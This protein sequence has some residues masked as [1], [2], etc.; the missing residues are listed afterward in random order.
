MAKSE[1]NEVMFGARGRV[2][3][4]VVFKN[5]GNN[6]TVISK[7]PK[8]PENPMY[9]A[10]QVAVKQ[11]FREAVLYAKGAIE[12][13]DLA[14]FYQVFAK[15]GISAYNLALADYCKAPEITLIDTV[16]YQGQISDQIKVRAIDNFRVTEVKVSIHDAADA[17]L[18]SGL[19]TLSANNVD[20]IYESSIQQSNLAGTKIT[21]EAKD[22]PGN[23][24]VKTI[25]L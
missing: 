21:A 23:T 18:E 15:P 22:T 7:R 1:N 14:T 2:G 25:T 11:K 3:N 17:L 19:A 5:F 8:R 4:L 10:K 24:T 16:N 9:T 13:P 6:Q 20:W 12:D